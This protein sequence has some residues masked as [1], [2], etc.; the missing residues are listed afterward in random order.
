MAF[1]K[2]DGN[3]NEVQRSPINLHHTHLFATDID[4]SLKFYSEWFGARVI[5]DGIFS[6]ARNVY[7]QIGGGRLHFY[8]QPPRGNGKNAFHHL[9]FQVDDLDELYNRMKRAGFPLRQPVKRFPEGAYLMVEAPDGVLLELFE[10]PP[11]QKKKQ[12]GSYFF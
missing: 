12:F 3:L 8:D 2:M 5:W 11:E 9:G 7:V 6:G 10:T 4:A 1:S